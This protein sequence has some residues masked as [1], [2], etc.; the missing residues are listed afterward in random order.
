MSVPGRNTAGALAK[1]KKMSFLSR[2][3]ASAVPECN[4]PVWQMESVAQ[5]D[6]C[7]RIAG[8]IT[9][10]WWS[11]LLLMLCGVL[12]T[13]IIVTHAWTNDG[14]WTDPTKH[15][16]P[17]MLLAAILF[18][19]VLYLALPPITAWST[20]QKYLGY[21]ARVR[22]MRASGMS[23][24]EIF[25]ALQEEHL[26]GIHATAIVQAGRMQA[27]ATRTA[28]NRVALGALSRR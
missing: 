10:S 6:A 4:M 5:A 11:V 22:S 23:T 25:N 13:V 9:A 18:W 3:T 21:K 15:P 7:G 28:G 16:F 17:A 19:V 14:P 20:R 26:A 12:V 1:L 2:F 27:R 8:T 24:K